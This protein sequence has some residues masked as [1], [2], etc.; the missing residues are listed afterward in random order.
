MTVNVYLKLDAMFFYS[1][2]RRTMLYL[3]LARATIPEAAKA[4]EPA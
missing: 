1:F 4:V 3:N 2:F